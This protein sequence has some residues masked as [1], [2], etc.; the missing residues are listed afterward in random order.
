MKR[1]LVAVV[2]LFLSASVAFVTPTNLA[3]SGGDPTVPAAWRV[4]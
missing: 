2:V 4:A 3:A 1:I